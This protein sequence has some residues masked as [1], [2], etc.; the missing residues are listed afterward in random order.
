M[1][2][3]D[4]I[5]VHLD[6]GLTAPRN[7]S[8]V[9]LYCDDGEAYVGKSRRFLSDGGEPQWVV[10]NEIANIS[11]EPNLRG[12]GAFTRIL[13]VLRD[14]QEPI[15]VESVINSRLRAF[16]LKNGFSVVPHSNPPSLVW[17]P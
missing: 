6:E 5:Q 16:L 17:M 12:Q 11:V 8:K 9:W 10:V 4:A 3:I 2:L 7:H 1:N 14:R 15:Y 13:Q